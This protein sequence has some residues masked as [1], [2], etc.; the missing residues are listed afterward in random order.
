MDSSI[1]ISNILD[2]DKNNFIS[3][4]NHKY[5]N[6]GLAFNGIGYVL[7]DFESL[8]YYICRKYNVQLDNMPSLLIL[9]YFDFL[10][11]EL[12][13]VF[14]DI[15][16]LFN[17]Q[18]QIFKTIKH[19][20]QL[21]F[22]CIFYNKIAENERIAALILG[23]GSYNWKSFLENGFYVIMLETLIFKIPYVYGQ[24]FIPYK[25]TTP[26]KILGIQNPTIEITKKTI[27]NYKEFLYHKYNI[28]SNKIK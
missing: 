13:C 11:T 20:V 12:H 2:E 26:S 9:E 21:C 5:T 25:S 17:N 16:Y 4:L 28:L 27:L 18:N 24:V 23:Y 8:I 19:Y 6:V 10:N 22:D 3:N 1:A 14:Q 15:R 7:I